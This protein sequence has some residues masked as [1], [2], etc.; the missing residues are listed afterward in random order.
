MTRRS[1]GLPSGCSNRRGPATIFKRKAE[2]ELKRLRD[3]F[4]SIAT[5]GTVIMEERRTC[6][7]C[8]GSGRYSEYE[9]VRCSSCG[10]SGRSYDDKPCYSCGGSGGKQERV[11]RTCTRC[12]GRGYVT[13]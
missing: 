2:T 13:D 12:F 7:A 4:N 3:H 11:E 1:A 6:P 5:K 10:G 9:W 8:A